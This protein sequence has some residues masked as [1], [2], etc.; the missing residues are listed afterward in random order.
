[1]L[2]ILSIDQSTSATKA[3][4]FDKRAKVKS[5]IDLPHRQFYPKE[6]WVEHDPLEI[7]NN[8]VELIGRITQE[9]NINSEALVCISISNQRE[10]IVA[11][12]KRTG[13]PIGNAVV[14][15]CMR[16]EGKCNQLKQAGFGD[17]FRNKTGLIIDPYFSASG[18][19][20]LLKN[21]LIT[22]KGANY[23]NILAGT[24]DSWLIWK[25][26]NGKV[27]A[28]DFSNACRTLLF[29]IHTLS[30]DKELCAH[31][32]I[33][34]VV[35]PEVKQSDQM[36]G[37]T[38]AR[39]ALGARIPICG[40][41]GD[42]H[43]ALFAQAC[44]QKGL[45]KV[46]YGTGSSVMMN[47]G[48]RPLAAPEGLVTSIGYSIGGNLAYVFEGN[49]HSTGATIKWLVDE[50]RLIVKSSESEKVATTVDSTEGVYFVPAFSGLGA[51]YWDNMARAC[52]SGIHSGTRKA[53]I[54]RAGLESIAYQ[55][56]DL[57]DLMTKKAGISLLEIRVDGGPT[58]ND[59]LMQFQ[60][61]MLDSKVAVSDVEEASALGAAFA[62][63]LGTGFWQHFDELSNLVTT[64][65]SF[66]PKMPDEVRK[67]LYDGW[68][69][70]LEKVKSN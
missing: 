63:G 60:S 48:D 42:S 21:Y 65:K 53:H 43:A 36:Y 54:V 38:D 15:Q 68:L 33:P 3:I 40:V 51:P 20:W 49:I 8:T 55:V 12:D 35:L 13:Q 57:L 27:H 59:F 64:K 4:L 18:L 66:K 30:W 17:E 50:L 47:I 70:A 1:M 41:M 22:N 37:E 23:D 7:Y 58:N 44:T 29:N 14:W 67:K 69:K 39:G 19:S 32:D 34:L 5:R 25:L 31:F 45:A 62:G 6:T 26:T 9:N 61:D 10:T 46:T 56:K 24:I 52:I 2:Y 11:W 16:G 28:T